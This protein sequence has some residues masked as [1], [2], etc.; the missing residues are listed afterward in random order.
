LP[1]NGFGADKSIGMGRFNTAVDSSFTADEFDTIEGNARLS[2]SL[3][4]FNNMGSYKVFYRL[5]T[6]FGKLG[7]NFAVFSPT[8]GKPRPFKKPILMY[9]PGAVFLMSESLEDRPLLEG[10]HSDTRIR[11][12]GVPITVPFKLLEDMSD[13]L[14]ANETR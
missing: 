6:K 8:G 12:C 4:S 1:E 13:A 7:G 5:R 11:H 14:N 10:I 9:E 2:L 3:C